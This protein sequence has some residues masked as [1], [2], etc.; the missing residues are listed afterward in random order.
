MQRKIPKIEAKKDI[1][2]KNLKL[3]IDIK[4]F[5]SIGIFL[6]LNYSISK[7][8]SFVNNRDKKRKSQIGIVKKF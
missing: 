5:C 3:K 4:A 1:I 8:E 2:D 6:K 7:M